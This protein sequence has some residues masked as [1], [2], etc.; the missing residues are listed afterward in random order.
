M[1]DLAAALD[2][3]RSR[4]QRNNV[5]L[6]QLEFGCVFD[7]DNAL[8]RSIR[9][10][11]ALR[12]VVLPEPVPPEIIMF[13]RARAAISKNVD[14]SVDMLPTVTKAE[15]SIMLFEN[16]LIEMHGPLRLSGGMITLTRLPSASLASSIGLDSST[17]RPIDEAMRWATCRTWASLRSKNQ[18]GSSF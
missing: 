10:E 18:E 6:L 13:R 2:I 17:R 8:A 1:A 7:G 15:K 16:F 3:G 11:R 5:G 12:S 4:L 9:R 14:S